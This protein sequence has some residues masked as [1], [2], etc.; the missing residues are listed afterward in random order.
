MPSS[1]PIKAKLSLAEYVVTLYTHAFDA[2]T[3]LDHQD[4]LIQDTVSEC[5]ALQ[6]FCHYV[7]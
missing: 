2:A 5:A 6:V 4:Y 3:R 7:C 1:T